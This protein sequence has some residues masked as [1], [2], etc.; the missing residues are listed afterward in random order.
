[1]EEV[2]QISSHE[3]GGITTVSVGGEIDVS[4]APSLRTKLLEHESSGSKTLVVDLLGVSFLD[5][6]GLGVLVGAF[7][8]LRDQG[9]TMRLVINQPRI[10][11]VFEVTDLTSI[12]SIFSTVDEAL[13]G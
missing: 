13:K 12:F 5:S 9:G 1:M 11:R 10:L 6:T 7:K 8:R 4:T 3:N 2:F